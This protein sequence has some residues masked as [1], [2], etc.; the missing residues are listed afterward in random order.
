[1]TACDCV[2][3]A[4]SGTSGWQI[5]EQRRS[6]HVNRKAFTLTAKNRLSLQWVN[7]Y[8]VKE[9]G[10]KA[11]INIKRVHR[12]LIETGSFQQFTLEPSIIFLIWV[13][14]LSDPFLF[15]ENTWDKC[16]RFR[17]QCD[18][19]SCFK[20]VWSPKITGKCLSVCPGPG[21]EIVLYNQGE[22]KG[23]EKHI[24]FININQMS[25]SH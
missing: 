21:F 7:L 12:F 8:C 18:C 24:F 2:F 5:A 1:M 19:W 22:L 13:H 11:W 4:E 15:Q 14:S 23:L 3:V 17:P 16:E 20:W 9:K 10:G 6:P 25:Q